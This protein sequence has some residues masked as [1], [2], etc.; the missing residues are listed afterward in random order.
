MPPSR[1]IYTY[2]FISHLCPLTKSIFVDIDVESARGDS[3][4]VSIYDGFSAGVT[5]VAVRPDS[6]ITH[7]R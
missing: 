4:T 6:G 1:G 3:M 2:S 5:D 7:R